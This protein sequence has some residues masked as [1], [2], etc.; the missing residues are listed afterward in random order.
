MT[1]TLVEDT[2]VVME[3]ATA[4]VDMA[5]VEA[6]MVPTADAVA[7]NVMRAIAEKRILNSPAR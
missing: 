4:V 3:A 5:A 2:V 1:A 6:D 7:L